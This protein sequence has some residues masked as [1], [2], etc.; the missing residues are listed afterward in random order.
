MDWYDITIIHE[1]SITFF[2]CNPYS[3]WYIVG[4]GHMQVLCLHDKPLNVSDKLQVMNTS[5]S[6]QLNGR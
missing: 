3:A 1:I 6:E 2:Q 4:P 5:N